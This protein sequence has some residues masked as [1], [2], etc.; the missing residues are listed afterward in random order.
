MCGLSAQAWMGWDFHRFAGRSTISVHISSIFGSFQMD[1]LRI[2]KWLWAARFFKTR[3]LAQLAIEQG[4]V[5]IDG[6]RVKVAR[7]VHVGDR[8][9]IE[10]GELKREIAVMGLATQR[11]PAPQ[12]QALYQ[13]TAQSIADRAARAESRRLAPEP[14]HAIEGGRPTK[15]SR[16]DIER[17]R[18]W[19]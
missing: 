3:G 17:L 9:E 5:K 11:G 6:A 12:A 14:A 1:P 8:V 7:A 10:I 15:R 13:E 4:R 19:T 2:D 16:R 18:D